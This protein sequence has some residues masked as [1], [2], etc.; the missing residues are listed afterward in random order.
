MTG[1]GRRGGAAAAR[2]EPLRVFHPG[3]PT[4]ITATDRGRRREERSSRSASRRTP[5]AASSGRC[6]RSCPARSRCRRRSSSGARRRKAR[7]GLRAGDAQEDR[8]LGAL[9]LHEQRPDRLLAERHAGSVRSNAGHPA[10]RDRLLRL[11]HPLLRLGEGAEPELRG[12]LRRRRR[13]YTGTMLEHCRRIPRGAAKPGDLVVW[14]PP[15][16]GPHVCVVVA[17]GANPWLVSHGSDS[18]PPKVFASPT[19]TTSAATATATP[20]GSACS[21]PLR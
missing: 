5:T 10:A 2:E 14:T 15:S 13:R 6:W 20:S 21:S 12:R 7:S 18:G 3:A 11:R 1:P 16:R 19:R 8:Q 9:G 4:A 17:T